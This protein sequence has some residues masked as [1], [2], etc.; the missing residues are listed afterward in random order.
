LRWVAAAAAGL[1]LLILL[2]VIGVWWSLH[3]SLAQ[4]DG[5]H[6]VL[7][8]QAEV[9][10]E[11]DSRGVPTIYATNRIDAARALGFLH[12]QERFFQIDLNRRAGAGELSELVG[13]VTLERD[14]QARVHR[15]R[16]RAKRALEQASPSD[17]ACVRAY[18]EGVNAGLQALRPNT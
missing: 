16:A 7:G 8:L 6:T 3:S 10:I 4:L 11:R 18:A 14:R 17:V 15:P 13:P 5:R 12:A 1:V 2:G 9:R